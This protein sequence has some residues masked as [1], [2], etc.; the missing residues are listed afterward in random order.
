MA[1]NK[2]NRDKLIDENDRRSFEIPKDGRIL[3]PSGDRRHTTKIR[4]GTLDTTIAFSK[5][6][7]A[8][9]PVDAD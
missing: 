7:L 1:K 5:R 6:H 2:R 9:I 8:T 4:E 3:V